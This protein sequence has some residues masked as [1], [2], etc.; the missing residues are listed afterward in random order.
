MSE[1]YDDFDRA[2]L[3]AGRKDRAPSR[4]RRNALAAGAGGATALL[5]TKATGSAA[6]TGA[7]SVAAKTATLAPTALLTWTA[8][9]LVSAGI[10]SSG[11]YAVRAGVAAPTPTTVTFASN[12]PPTTSTSASSLAVQ[13][14][15]EIP[16]EPVNTA[17]PGSPDRAERPHDTPP[18]ADR[19]A[20]G[21]NTPAPMEREDEEAAIAPPSRS[22]LAEEIAL[23][24]SARRALLAGDAATVLRLVGEHEASFAS[25]AFVVERDALRVEALALAGRKAEA[26]RE[27][28]RF[29]QRHGNT[30][31]AP[32]IAKIANEA[33]P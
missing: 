11:I 15:A 31:Q 14:P 22:H 1:S 32:R 23:V 10:V 26:K 27:A 29:I 25:G 13:A 4:L 24:D 20:P 21:R 7:A 28:R 12:A 19:M 16:S 17:V 30:A 8:I 2:L 9:A 5:A 3:R 18:R 6:T 33:N